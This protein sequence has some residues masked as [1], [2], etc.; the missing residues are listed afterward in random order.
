M[1]DFQINYLL[2]AAIDAH[3]RDHLIEASDL[4]V[5]LLKISPQ[6]SDATHLI[7]LIAFQSNNF[8]TVAVLVE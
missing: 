1:S 2:A 4:Y 7:G 6:H 3:Q 8:V 5:K